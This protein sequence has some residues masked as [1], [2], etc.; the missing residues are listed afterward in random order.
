MMSSFPEKKNE[1]VEELK[2]LF[3]L[4]VEEQVK[5][6]R[7]LEQKYGSETIK[8]IVAKMLGGKISSDWGS[9]AET[10]GKNDLSTFID[11]LWNKYSGQA[12]LKWTETK[13]ENKTV[14]NCTYCPH[15]EKFKE[16][17]AADWGYE[18]MC[19]ADYYMLKGWNPNIRFERTKTLMQGDDCCDH[20]YIVESN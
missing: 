6:L 11:I 10:G 2:K 7:E 4:P 18:L 20:T 8:E 16:L 9:M 19:M 14:M 13:K 12:G 15:A 5:N 1:I 3:V 17:E